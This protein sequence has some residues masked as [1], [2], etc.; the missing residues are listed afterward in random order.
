VVTEFGAARLT[1]LGTSERAAA[2][3]AVAHPRFRD[4]LEREER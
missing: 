1:G 4:T 2:L 3:I